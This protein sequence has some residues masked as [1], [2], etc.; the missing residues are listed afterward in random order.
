MVAF[1]K[2]YL[3]A[4]SPIR[5]Q[6]RAECFFVRALGRAGQGAPAACFNAWKN[7]RCRY[8]A[9]QGASIAAEAPSSARK[10]NGPGPPLSIRARGV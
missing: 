4:E 8:D 7:S 9:C 1:A 3:S 10:R 2:E 5:S 6:N